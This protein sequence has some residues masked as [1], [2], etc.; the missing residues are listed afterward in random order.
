MATPPA[1]NLPGTRRQPGD[2]G[3]AFTPGDADRRAAPVPPEDTGR[4]GREG[5]PYAAPPAADQTGPTGRAA[6][7]YPATGDA[8]HPDT[9]HPDTAT[10]DAAD[11]D[12]AAGHATAGTGPTDQT[13]P[14][15]RTVPVTPTIKRTRISGT[16]VAVIVAAIV[17]IFLL[18]FILQNLT[19]VTVNFLGVSGSLPLGVAM[20][21][22]AI[23]GV[24]LLAL[25][26]TARILQLR[27]FTKRIGTSGQQ[28]G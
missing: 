3:P 4:H 24:I 7:D 11:G 17:L 26:G 9:A 16:W 23:A 12:A 25:I 6:P 1:E 19:T 5:D 28:P 22:A 13:G 27:R 18:I 15:A 14:I 21:F 10:G 20:L 8:A 2:T